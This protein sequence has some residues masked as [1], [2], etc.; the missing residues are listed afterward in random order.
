[1]MNLT[2]K[3]IRVLSLAKLQAVLMAAIGLIVGVIYGVIIMVFGAA[4]L[5]QTEAGGAAAVGSVVGGLVV[6]VIAPI[7]YG[8]L[9]FV[10]GA[11]SALVFNVA[12]GF[13]G[14]LELQV[15]GAAAELFATPPP[16]P[17][18]QW[19]TDA[20]QATPDARIDEPR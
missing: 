4:L 20:Y 7:F 1:M 9:G 19:S 8:V 17:P 13:M 10:F 12:A 18:Q 6:M 16:L 11:I 5:S 3:R 14:G 15:E 2:V